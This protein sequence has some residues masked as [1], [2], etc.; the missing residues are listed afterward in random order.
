M[1]VQIPYVLG[2]LYLFPIEPNLAFIPSLTTLL[3]NSE[4]FCF[5]SR[6]WLPVIVI[7]TFTYLM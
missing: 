7:V 2:T 4:L 5:N 6:A 3:Y 1:D